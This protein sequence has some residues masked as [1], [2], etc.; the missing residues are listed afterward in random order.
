MYIRTLNRRTSLILGTE[1]ARK[2]GIA[3]F[4]SSVQECIRT[5]SVCLD[6]GD[7]KAADGWLER[8]AQHLWGFNR[9]F[10]WN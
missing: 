7:T 2:A 6:K 9:P 1:E 4:Y 3:R 10:G 8:G 5:A